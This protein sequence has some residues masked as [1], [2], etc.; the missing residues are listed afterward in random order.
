MTSEQFKLITWVKL[1]REK[2]IPYFDPVLPL[3]PVQSE[4]IDH[5]PINPFVL[6]VS[7][8]NP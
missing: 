6:A 5:P 7:A 8:P 1:A 3:E 4:T 2:G